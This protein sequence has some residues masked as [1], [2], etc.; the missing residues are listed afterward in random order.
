MRELA[1]TGGRPEPSITLLILVHVDE[2]L[3]RSRHEAAEHLEG[4]YKLPLQVVER[5]A[6]LGPRNQVAQELQSYL[7]VGV[8]ELILMTLG[9]APLTQ[10]ER[11]AEVCAMLKATPTGA[12]A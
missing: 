2:D 10:Y 7:E 6:A 1:A 11:L 8:T 5:W 9:R 12:T 3:E 4:Q